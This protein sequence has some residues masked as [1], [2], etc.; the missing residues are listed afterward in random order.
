MG[1]KGQRFLT[2]SIDMSVDIKFWAG[3]NGSVQCKSV[4]YSLDDMG[5]ILGQVLPEDFSFEL[6]GE[7]RVEETETKVRG[8]ALKNALL[9]G[10]VGLTIGGKV[11]SC[12]CCCFL[13]LTDPLRIQ[14]WSQDR[15]NQTKSTGNRR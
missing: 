14:P 3:P 7:L 6:E 2:I 12:C 4:G 11:G 8:L 15:R 9:S 13:T 10:D 1:L 5:K